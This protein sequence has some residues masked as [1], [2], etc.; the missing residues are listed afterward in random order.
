LNVDIEG[1]SRS[2]WAYSLACGTGFYLSRH[3]F[4]EPALLYHSSTDQKLYGLV[5]LN[6][7]YE[8]EL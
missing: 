2:F 8:I 6:V 4:I 1:E 3:L 7:G 5:S